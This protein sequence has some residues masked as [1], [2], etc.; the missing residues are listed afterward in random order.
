MATVTLVGV[1]QNTADSVNGWS[2]GNFDGE[3]FYQGSGSV[4]AKVG[5][6]TSAFVH[7]G[8][9]KNFSVGGANEGDH[10]IVILN[11]LTPGKLDTNAN[12]GLRIRVGSSTTAYGDWYVDGVDT[13]PATTAF[14]PYIVD[15]ASDFDVSAGGLSTTGNPNQLNNATTFGGVFKALSGIMGN[16]NNSLV[17][18]ITIGKGLR[19]TGTSGLLNDFVLAD[20]GNENNR[21]GWIT[22]RD[23]VVYCQGKLYFGSSSSSLAFDDENQVLVFQDVNVSDTHFELISENASNNIT[24]DRWVIKAAGSKKIT[25]TLNLGTWLIKNGLIQGAYRMDLGSLVTIQDQVINDTGEIIQNGANLTGAT[26]SNQTAPMVVDSPAT[27]SN[28]VFNSIGTG[29]AWTLE[30]GVGNITL[31]N[32]SFNGYG[33]DDTANAAINYTGT[34][35][36]TISPTGGGGL[37][38]NPTS[39][40][41]VQENL[42]SLTFTGLISGG[43][44]RIYDDDGDGNDITLGTN[45]EGV[46][47]LSGTTY[48][49]VYPESESGSVINAQFMDPLNFEEQVQ[50]IPLPSTSQSIPFILRTEDNV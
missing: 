50:T 10:I 20:E 22:T 48:T 33:A 39:L 43:E 36:I 25:F 32:I 42:I 40:V 14:L 19:A 3:L 41:T 26:I 44:F 47:A 45:R 29:H 12:G 27:I 16:F 11:S 21:Y 35:P 17:D 6:G 31:N 30:E 18:Q 8:T 2:G 9:S 24:F 13:K 37:T 28:C 4:G 38:V 5:S 1:V 34:T 46:E 23:T 49:V 15:P 7:T